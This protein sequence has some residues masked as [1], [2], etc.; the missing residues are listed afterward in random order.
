MQDPT[1][2]PQP[3]ADDDIHLLDLLVTVADNIKLLV[4]G[5]L[6]VGLAA[7]GVG[8]VLPQSFESTSILGVEKLT[9]KI[10]DNEPI[11]M[12]NANVVATLATTAAVLDPVAQQL[13]LLNQ[14]LSVDQA[15]S[16]LQGQVKAS[17]GRNDKLLTLTT[18]AS[19]PQQAQQLNQLVLQ[20]I[21]EQT[22][23]RGAELARLQAQLAQ[24]QTSYATSTQLEQT[25]AKLLA[26]GKAQDKT[27]ETYATLLAANSSRLVTIQTLEAQLAGLQTS[28]VVQPATLPERATKPKKSLIAV[29]AALATGFALLLFV[30]VRQA[31]RNAGTQP[32]SA[33]KLARIRRGLGLR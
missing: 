22:R 17:V 24:E 14:G 23:P 2:T 3:P 5:P 1:H 4:L 28:D 15:R 16:R 31:L 33:A 30:F 29:V 26:S 12:Y 18:T 27:S 32:E 20:H 6:L 11:P 10:G 8:Y 7:L 21:F 9:Q 19:Q 25:L 13:G